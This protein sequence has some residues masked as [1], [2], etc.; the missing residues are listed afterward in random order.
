[1]HSCENL[2]TILA[3]N[4]TNTDHKA[5]VW[6]RADDID[7]CPKVTELSAPEIDDVRVYNDD[8]AV[9]TG[10]DTITTLDG[11]VVSPDLSGSFRWTDTWVLIAG[12]WKCVASHSSKI[13][14][15]PAAK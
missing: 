8:C 14:G 6:H 2:E 3:D 9:V 4:Y 10:H 7:H 15:L 13:S 11:G 1:M 12:E 5:K